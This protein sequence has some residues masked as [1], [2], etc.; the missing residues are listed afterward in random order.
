MRIDW[1]APREGYFDRL[2]PPQLRLA[3]IMVEQL[4]SEGESVLDVVSEVLTPAQVEVGRR[5]L[6]N[7][8][9]VADEH[10][11]SAV[12]EAALMAAGTASSRGRNDTTTAT[13]VLAC[14][15][16]EWHTLPLRMVAEVLGEAG[17]ECVFLGPSVPPAHL[18]N[19][20][21]ATRPLALALHSSYPLSLDGAADSIAAAHQAGVP[22]IV[23]GRG[24]GADDHR[25]A[26]VGADSWG[27]D[28]PAAIA[29]LTSWLDHT[30]TSL[31][32]PDITADETMP[33]DAELVAVR[34]GVV[35]D[36]KRR[37][38]RTAGYTDDQWARTNEDVDFIVRF[39]VAAVRH[40]DD[41]I[42][43]DFTVWLRDLLAVRHVP[44]DILDVSMRSIASALEAKRPL[45]SAGIE[46]ALTGTITTADFR[47][48]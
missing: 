23:G 33:G 38:P 26:A 36:L 16:G 40:R 20:L 27:D 11:A 14:G 19:F 24:F 8:W 25:A 47:T 37:Y 2:A 17:F 45:V 28:L 3:A 34:A 18:R 41:R 22:V 1:S 29:T 15:M 9:S 6:I 30:P 32:A 35:A 31:A 7:E 10:A 21:D 44:P 39:G 46:R 4:V 42:L 48:V 5:W 12:T 13:V 43:S